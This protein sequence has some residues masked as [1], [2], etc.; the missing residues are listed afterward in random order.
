MSLCGSGFGQ[1][2]LCR[3]ARF[4]GTDLGRF[5]RLWAFCQNR[6]DRAVI[7]GF[8]RGRFSG[9]GLARNLGHKMRR[10][11]FL[12][13]DHLGCGAFGRSGGRARGQGHGGRGFGR[14]RGCCGGGRRLRCESRGAGDLCFLREGAAELGGPPIVTQGREQHAVV[15]ALH[16]GASEIIDAHAGGTK[17]FEAEAA[18]HLF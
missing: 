7:N 13:G 6:F 5:C 3:K 16:R 2:R 9:Q 14:C 15:I 18:G 11:G 17:M 4:G 10:C 1:C 8:G 12:S